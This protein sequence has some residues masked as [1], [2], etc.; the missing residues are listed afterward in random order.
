MLTSNFYAL[1]MHMLTLTLTFT[2]TLTIINS[3]NIVKFTCRGAGKTGAK[4]FSAPLADPYA[5]ANTAYMSDVD[6]ILRYVTPWPVM[7]SLS[8]DAAPRAIIIQ[9][10]R[11]CPPHRSRCW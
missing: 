2:L 9:I 1:T 4:R 10:W 5:V 6:A 8:L 3:E 11:F 7:R